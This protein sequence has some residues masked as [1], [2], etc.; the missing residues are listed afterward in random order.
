MTSDPVT[1]NVARKNVAVTA[2]SVDGIRNRTRRADASLAAPIQGDVAMTTTMAASM[3]S[4]N[5]MSGAP[6]S[7]SHSAK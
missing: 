6:L 3:V 1:P 5:A 4:D 2:N 7:V